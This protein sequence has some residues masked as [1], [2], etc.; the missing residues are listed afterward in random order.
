MH[1]DF[2]MILERYFESMRFHCE[3]FEKHEFTGVAKLLLKVYEIHKYFYQARVCQVYE[4]FKFETNFSKRF[5]TCYMQ[6][7]YIKTQLF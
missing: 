7:I 3:K 4:I 2:R 5:E 6:D 1:T